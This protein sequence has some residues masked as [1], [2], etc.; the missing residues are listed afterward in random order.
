MVHKII[1][2]KYQHVYLIF[3]PTA[4]T[5]P[6]KRKNWSGK[7]YRAE[8]ETELSGVLISD[9][10][11][12]IRRSENGVETERSG[13]EQKTE[14]SGAQMECRRVRRRPT[15]ITITTTTKT[16]TRTTTTKNKK[17]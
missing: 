8:R 3:S 14:L 15:K 11:D 17:N 6:I 12:E 2:K 4:T 1:R 9:A 13:V 7:Q 5:R 10:S 16:T